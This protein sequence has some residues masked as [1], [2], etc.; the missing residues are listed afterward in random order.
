MTMHTLLQRLHHD[1]EDDRA[2]IDRDCITRWLMCFSANKPLILEHPR[3]GKI[4]YSGIGFVGSPE[5]VFDQFVRYSVE[6]LVEKHTRSVEDFLPDVDNLDLD[7][8]A[9]RAA[10]ML[11]SVRAQL[12]DRAAVI[13]GRLKGDGFN[14]KRDPVRVSSH[15]QSDVFRRLRSRVSVLKRE[16][17]QSVTVSVVTISRLLAHVNG[18]Q[19]AGH[20][21][22]PRQVKRLSEFLR[23]SELSVVAAALSHGI[24]VPGWIDAARDEDQTGFPDLAWPD[25]R[26]SELGHAIA[27]T[28]YLAKL[29][30]DEVV[31]FASTYFSTNSGRYD[32]HVARMADDVFVPLYTNLIDYL[33]DKGL[34]EAE[35]KAAST[36]YV[37]NMHQ[38]VGVA[39]QQGTQASTQS[40][41]YAVDAGAAAKALDVLDKELSRVA[42]PPDLLA[43]I[44]ADIA[45]L[46]AQLSKSNPSLS[47]VGEATKS[48][49]SITEG[50]IAGMITPEAIAAV[51]ALL[52]ATR[53]G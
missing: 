33:Q 1:L 22:F 43:D 7:S 10:G 19:S 34:L 49:R 46:R 9:D 21:L 26:N 24:D 41:H 14:P 52:A 36:S 8:V 3:L 42:V 28:H 6:D 17:S 50:V 18:T 31:D 44:K 12:Y 29:P 16:R 45:T 37:L 35:T 2:T 13:K 53:L 38:P 39:V 48:I 23:E 25:E 32:D 20:Q 11:H 30:A 15:E 51:S 4:H 27:L 5:L 40:M 47:I